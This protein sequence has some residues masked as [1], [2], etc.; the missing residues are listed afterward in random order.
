M[1]KTRSTRKGSYHRK[2]YNPKRKGGNLGAPGAMTDAVGPYPHSA[3]AGAGNLIAQHPPLGAGPPVTPGQM[4]GSSLLSPSAIDT[5]GS[6]SSLLSG[7][8]G[9]GD[10]YLGTGKPM[11]GGKKHHKN[12]HTKHHKNHHGRKGGNMLSEIAVPAVLLIAN[13]TLGKKTGKILPHF[14]QRHS[15]KRFNRR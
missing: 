7:L 15:R 9:G 12:H 10:A 6:G 5:H 14:G 4:G 11:R 3:Q 2:G 1:S 13:Q 8:N